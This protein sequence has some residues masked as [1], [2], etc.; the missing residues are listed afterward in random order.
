[1]ASKGTKGKEA[2]KS[3]AASKRLRALLWGFLIGI[4]VCAFTLAVGTTNFAK[5]TELITLDLRYRQR[6]PVRFHPDVGYIDFDDS[7]I[8]L[9]GRWV[10]PRHRM[11]ALVRTLDRYDARAAGYDVFFTEKN[12]VVLATDR[13]AR[14][15][16]DTGTAPPPVEKVTAAFRDYD[17]EFEE[18]IRDAGNMY[19]GQFMPQP[20]AEMA[21][22]SPTER[23]AKIQNYIDSQFMPTRTPDQ[24]AALVVAE[25]FA[26][27][28]D[29]AMDE[30]LY[31]AIGITTVLPELSLAAAGVGYA[32]I[33]EDLDPA[34]RLY[35]LFM[36]FNRKAYP[37]I[38]VVMLCRLLD[39]PVQN[40]RIVPGEFIEFPNA[41]TEPPDQSVLAD[42]EHPVR[43]EAPRGTIR[44]PVDQHGQ[45]LV[46]WAGSFMERGLHISFRSISAFHALARSKE[47]AGRYA[48]VPDSYAPLRDEIW[49]AISEDKLVTDEEG[50]RLAEEIALAHVVEPMLD[51]GVSPVDA[52]TTVT[53]GPEPICPPEPNLKDV[54]TALD[55]AHRARDGQDT[56]SP[57]GETWN[58]EISRNIAFFAKRDRLQEV[59]PLYFPRPSSAMWDGEMKEFSPVDLE[60]KMLMIGLTGIG[61]IDLNPMPFERACPMVA[62]HTNALNTILTKQFLQFPEKSDRYIAVLILG[63]GASLLCA[64]LSP[65]QAFLLCLAMGGGYTWQVWSYW[66]ND[67]R[68]VPLVEPLLA[69]SLTYVIH[70]VIE[71]IR[72]LR[73]KQQIRGLFSTMVS[74]NVLKLM[75]QNPDK[76]SLT[77]ERKPGTMFFSG[78]EGFGKVTQGVAPEDLSAILGM[79]LTPTSEIIMDYDGYIDKYEGH[80]IM[81]DFGVPLDD[82]GHPWKCCY[83]AI[84]QQQDIE[85][86]RVFVAARYGEDVTVAMG[87]N[88]GYVSAGNMGSEK[89]MQYTV[90]GDAVNVSARFRPANIIYNTGVITGE[91]TEPLIRDTVE[92]RMLDKLLLKGKT[93]PTT[94]YEVMGWKEESYLKTKAGKPVPPSLFVR[95]R[96]CP[97]EKV[98]GYILFWRRR[99]KDHGVA[100]C[101]EIAA[102]FESVVPIAEEIMIHSATLSISSL[103]AA[104]NR[105]EDA[106]RSIAPESWSTPD[107]PP[108]QEGDPTWMQKLHHWAIRVEAMDKVLHD[109]HHRGAT[110]P[111]GVPAVVELLMQ[112]VSLAGKIQRLRENLPRQ[113][114]L[115]IAS[116]N[117]ALQTIRD[118]LDGKTLGENSELIVIEKREEYVKAAEQFYTSLLPR[119]EEYHKMMAK[120]GSL[121]ERQLRIR[122][123]F[124]EA[125]RIH[126]D[127]KWDESL[128]LLSDARALDPADGP[129]NGL[130]ERVTG[131]KAEPPG[132]AWQGEFVQKKK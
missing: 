116:I 84:E 97:P 95:W 118:W 55:V 125:L 113:S 87:I 127:R 43:K 57:L 62:L 31:K 126:W 20:D 48:P 74:P 64:F 120:I 14:E 111:D 72:A 41:L 18:A 80:I 110:S 61:T 30:H 105:V 49:T 92:L 63:L 44:I 42:P 68:W 58:R 8:A 33:I 1:M 25:Q 21:A 69:L 115:G 34:V 56:T 29:S 94:I 83:S 50:R 101:G 77:G 102:F 19:L 81:A 15:S 46:N 67:G 131:Y 93:K 119:S 82:P 65:S 98:F 117:R 96:T 7:S 51:A 3:S 114:R 99:E 9:F 108:R 59:S 66:R 22:G 11:V 23:R 104:I 73:A 39:V 88:S 70:V 32:Q 71:F 75:E 17:M 27:D 2:K 13:L 12:D 76:F 103:D 35:P 90:M 24:L 10:W 129:V 107:V 85:A 53:S 128:T 5:K 37:S 4:L 38:A 130:I 78:I 121:T 60:N 45:M 16:S 36:Y 79:Y 86:F 28:A 132:P 40:I 122:S 26:V 91:A 6:P 54:I 109:A 124:E 100:L 89:K 106:V 123:L 47:I 112:T 52:W